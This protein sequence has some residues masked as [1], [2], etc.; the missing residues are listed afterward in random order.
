[1]LLISSLALLAPSVFSSADPSERAAQLVSQ[2]RL[3]E[4]LSL[5]AG[6]KGLYTGN[7][8]GVERLGIP[9]LSMQDG[10]QGFRATEK[11]GGPGSSTAWPS[12]LSLAAA[13]DAEL[14]ERWGVAMGQEFR[15]KVRL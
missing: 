7:V 9:P 3:P 12:E 13:W 1:M 10:P 6:Q 11:T 8:P 2:L 14:A 4:K 15:M 5:M